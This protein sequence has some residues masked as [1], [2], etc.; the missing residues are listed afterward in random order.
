MINLFF[1]FLGQIVSFLTDMLI[2]SISFQQQT[3]GA[4]NFSV[5]Q[6]HA[7][8]EGGSTFRMQATCEA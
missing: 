1:F 6:H 7:E 8:E 3:T 5:C 4:M 2:F